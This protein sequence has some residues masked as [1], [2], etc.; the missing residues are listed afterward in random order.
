MDGSNDLVAIGDRLDPSTVLDAYRRGVF[1][2]PVRKNIL[3]WWSPDPRAIIPI[4]RFHV[5]RSLKRSRRRFEITV[6]T[7]FTQVVE[8]CADPSRPHGWITPAIKSAYNEL[9]QL[10]W[11]H[12]VETRRISD[13]RLVGG[14]YGLEIGGLFAGESMFHTET[15]ASKAALASMFDRLRDTP[16]ANERIFDVQWLTPHL[17]SLGGVEISRSDYL[18]RLD[19]VVEL[20]R[21]GIF[22]AVREAT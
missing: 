5:S 10:G 21:S 2:M 20:E 18:G 8:A 7:A 17:A 3:G 22:D 11:A 4:D 16:S 14:V 15:D 6:D 12:S 9:H 1:P 19:T 13:G